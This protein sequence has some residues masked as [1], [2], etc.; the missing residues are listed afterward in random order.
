M[1]WAEDLARQLVEIHSI[2]AGESDRPLLYD[3]NHQTL[4]FTQRLLPNADGRSPTGHADISDAVRR[5]QSTLVPTPPVLVHLDYWHGNV[6][7]NRGRISA[8]LD[9][10]FAGYGDP[11]IDVAYFRMNMHLRGIKDAADLFL[12]AYERQTGEAVKNLGFRELAAAAQCLPSPLG[13]VPMT[14]EMGGAQIADELAVA[15]YDEFVAGALRRAY[16]G[17]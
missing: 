9:W 1:E 8:V 6:L 2:R 5:L 16:E 13:W 12:N 11:A 7:W 15:Q 10:D 14:R 3:G 4:F 17:R